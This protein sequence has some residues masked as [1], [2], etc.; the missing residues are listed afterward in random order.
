MSIKSN[1]EDVIAEVNAPGG[2][3]IGDEI[4]IQSLAALAGGETS[5]EWETYM[6]R[7]ADNAAQLARLLATDG[8][9]GNEKMDEARRA[10]VRNGNCGGATIDG[11]ADGTGIL[12]QGL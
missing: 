12:D 7:F 9:K 6:N 8:T 11:L 2:E 10:L 4:Q 5:P 3:S 1:I